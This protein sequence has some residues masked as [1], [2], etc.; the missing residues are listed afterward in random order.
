MERE[1]EYD[2][3]FDAASESSSSSLLTSSPS[4]ISEKGD[5]ID[6]D[7]AKDLTEASRSHKLTRVSVA[8]NSDLFAV[9]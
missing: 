9:R 3:L 1:P 2:R 6:C 7:R 5:T 8:V 4:S